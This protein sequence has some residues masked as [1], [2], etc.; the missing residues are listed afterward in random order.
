MSRIIGTLYIISAPSGA[1]KTS[2][3]NA[4]IQELSHLKLSVSHT[5]RAP[6]PKEVD[7]YN[8][9]FIDQATFKQ[10][11][12][13]GDFMESA[14]V[15]GNF[16]G[17]SE[18]AVKKMLEQGSDVIL[19]IDWQGAEQIKARFKDAISIFILPPDI[20][21]LQERLEVRAEDSQEIIDLRMSKAKSELKHWHKADYLVVN[22]DFEQAL[23]DLQAIIKVN[24]L[25]TSKQQAIN[26][27]LLKK[28]NQ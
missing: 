13:N 6:R 26:H 28:L 3:V 5:T 10:M 4:L 20:D 27:L 18:Q 9:H 24:R 17:T 16:Y 21:T 25:S 15:F 11:Q 19:E 12:K 8:Y 1:G 7:G 22:D 23:E 2:L 14:E